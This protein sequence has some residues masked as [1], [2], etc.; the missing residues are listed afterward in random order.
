MSSSSSETDSELYKDDAWRQED[1][2]MYEKC[3]GKYC[4]FRWSAGLVKGDRSKSVTVGLVTDHES[5]RELRTANKY[6][7]VD[8]LQIE[9]E[10]SLDFYKLGKDIRKFILYAD[11]KCERFVVGWTHKQGFVDE[12]VL[13][14]VAGPYSVRSKEEVD[15]EDVFEEISQKEVKR[16]L[17]ED[18]KRTKRKKVIPKRQENTSPKKVLYSQTKEEPRLPNEPIP[19]IYPIEESDFKIHKDINRTIKRS[20]FIL[21][22]CGVVITTE[23]HVDSMAAHIPGFSFFRPNPRFLPKTS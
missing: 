17:S 9:V 21:D 1:I 7:R 8:Y 2:R 5:S 4:K 3:V 19:E 23:H 15:E 12:N 6:R 10:D 22:S 14:F 20:K 16:K 11:K 18:Q 13:D